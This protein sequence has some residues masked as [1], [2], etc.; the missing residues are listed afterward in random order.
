MH[1]RQAS[2]WRLIDDEIEAFEAS[3]SGQA[4]MDVGSDLEVLDM[5]NEAPLSMVLPVEE[6]PVMRCPRTIVTEDNEDEETRPDSIGNGTS[7]SKTGERSTE[8]LGSGPGRGWNKDLLAVRGSYENVKEDDLYKLHQRVYNQNVI[9]EAARGT[10]GGVEIFVIG[11]VIDGTMEGLAVKG[12][13]SKPSTEAVAGIGTGE[14]VQ[15][16]VFVISISE[17]EIHW[18]G[19][20]IIHKLTNIEF[21]I[22]L[23]L[24]M[25]SSIPLA[26]EKRT[27]QSEGYGFVEFSLCVAAEKVLRV[28]VVIDATTGRSKGNGF[29]RFGDDNYRS[30]ALT[31]MNGAYS[32]NRSMRINIAT[33]RKPSGYQQ[34][35]QDLVKSKPIDVESLPLP[36]MRG[37]VPSIKLARSCY[38]SGLD[39]F[40]FS[41]IGRLDLQKIR[42]AE[43]WKM[44]GEEVVIGH[45]P[46]FCNNYKVIGHVVYEYKELTKIRKEEEE[47]NEQKEGTE[48][49]LKIKKKNK[50]KNKKNKDSDKEEQVQGKEKEKVDTE[51]GVLQGDSEVSCNLEEGVKNGVCSGFDVPPEQCL[52]PPDTLAIMPVVAETWADLAALDE[53]DGLSEEEELGVYDKVD[54]GFV[55]PV[56]ALVSTEKAWVTVAKK[57]RTNKTK[58]AIKG[59]PP[60]TRSK[61]IGNPKIKSTLKK[62]IEDDKPS[63]FAL[64]EPKVDTCISNVSKLGLK[65]YEVDLI[66]NE[67]G[68]VPNL[69]ILWKLGCTKP[70]VL[71]SSDQQITVWFDDVMLTFIHANCDIAR[72]TLWR[73]LGNINGNMVPWL[74]VGDYNVIL[75]SGEKKGGVPSSNTAISDF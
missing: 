71:S 20:K 62:L 57:K 17:W 5:I 54:D 56:K 64:A 34:Q 28:K 47:K 18:I 72:R 13:E 2:R 39:K 32:S 43:V 27:S 69:W 49:N 53:E 38:Q 65:E 14:P 4:P 19:F 75:S 23:V 58:N 46:K 11:V 74:V 36:G 10:G 22:W 15:E 50:K 68:G 61:G 1:N 37:E 51:S 44:A 67:H 55:T 16:E 40:K 70:V 45:L 26:L 9:D 8:F 6:V 31:E 12:S 25:A 42:L 60:L 33:P 59:R 52:F 24:F 73:N 29:V 35:S 3:I 21:E 7:S 41:L 63:I 48:G 66:C 30:Q